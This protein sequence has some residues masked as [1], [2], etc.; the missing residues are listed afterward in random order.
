MLLVVGPKFSED[1]PLLRA[2]LYLAFAIVAEVIATS[3]LKASHG[4]TKPAPSA[5]VVLGYGAAFYLLSLSLKLGMSI[6]VA[7]AIWS[8]LGIVLIAAVGVVLFGERLDL[9]AIVG[10]ALIVLGVLVLN[11]FSGAVR[12]G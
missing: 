10:F 9:A 3:S 12:H 1:T 6:G 7:Y 4:F 5:L 11:L 2:Y 8:G